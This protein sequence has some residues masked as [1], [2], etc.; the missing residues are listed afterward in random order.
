MRTFASS[1]GSRRQPSRDAWIAQYDAD[2]DDSILWGEDGA[3]RAFEIDCVDRP[4]DGSEP[5]RARGV[6]SLG[7][8][9]DDPGIVS[10]G[11]WLAAGLVVVGLATTQMVDG[12]LFIAGLAEDDVTLAQSFVPVFDGWW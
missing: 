10:V 6:P 1:F 4:E 9:R 12:P 8:K 2:Q 5:L 11:L 3:R 7:G